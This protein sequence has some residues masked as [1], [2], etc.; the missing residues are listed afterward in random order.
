MGAPRSPFIG[1]AHV[2]ALKAVLHIMFTGVWRTGS[3]DPLVGLLLM[4]APS[5]RHL[6]SAAYLRI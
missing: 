1:G 4:A 3:D 5:K 2:A 6:R